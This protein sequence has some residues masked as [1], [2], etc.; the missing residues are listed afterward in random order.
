MEGL[1]W[2]VRKLGVAM[3]LGY[4]WIRGYDRGGR[5]GIR[6]SLRMG[7]HREPWIRLRWRIWVAMGKLLYAHAPYICSPS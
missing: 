4:G 1:F 6:L 5:H 7:S 2:W 3:G